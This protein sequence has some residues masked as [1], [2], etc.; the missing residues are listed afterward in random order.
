VDVGGVVGLSVGVLLGNQ[1]DLL[2]LAILGGVL[3]DALDSLLADVREDVGDKEAGL[4]GGHFACC[5][6]LVLLL[7][8]LNTYVLE[9]K[10]HLNFFSFAVIS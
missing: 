10:K 7:F 1:V 2:D 5:L 3:D 8:A 9:L 4:V 6:L